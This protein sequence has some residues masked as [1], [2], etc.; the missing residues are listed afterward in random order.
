MREQTYEIK[1]NCDSAIEQ[2]T[3]SSGILEDITK[4]V[5]KAKCD[6]KDTTFSIA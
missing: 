6:H 1:L 2:E 4:D 3:L 5:E